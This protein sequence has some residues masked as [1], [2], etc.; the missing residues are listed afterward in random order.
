MN[1][2]LVSLGCDKN[3]VDSEKILY[4][5][6]SNGYSITHDL[7]NVDVIIINTCA[8]IE[9]AKQESV[10]VI[11]EAIQFQSKNTIKIIVVGCLAQR[12]FI[13]LKKEFPT[14]SI[15]CLNEYEKITN[16]I[17]NSNLQHIKSS[18]KTLSY[19]EKSFDIVHTGR[20]LTTPCHIA[21]LKIADGCDNFC[22]YCA[23]PHIRGR[24]RSIPIDIL[25]KE[26][27]E[28][29]KCG[30]K[31]LILVAQD[32]TRYGCD[33]YNKPSLIKLLQEL[34][35]INFWKIRILYAYPEFVEND[36]IE[37]ISDNKN[38]AK[39]I[40]MP[41][42]HINDNLLKSMN[43]K[44]T[45]K[46]ILEKLDDIHEINPDISIRSSFIVGYPGETKQQFLELVDF[47]KTGKIDYAGFFKYSRE[48]NTK[49]YNMK[50]QISKKIKEERFEA[51]YNLQLSNMIEKNNLLIGCNKEIIVDA[52]DYDMGCFVGR[53]EQSC[54]EV[55]NVVYIN[56]TANQLLKCGDIINAKIDSA[57]VDLYATM[58]N[59]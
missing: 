3:R 38:L 50:N 51:L 36:L 13:E 22:S 23:I 4:M 43:R 48:E 40:D 25:L 46:Y 35:N 57:C 18:D 31:E 20:I 58:A 6:E 56:A 52:F 11:L 45:R 42:Q 24:Y 29:K 15:V 54:Y 53:L 16:V 9:D 27:Y 17:E 44:I 34:N 59:M 55:D 28:L 2:G 21:Y 5:L 1:I 39:Y 33:L 49:A 32:V 7:Q 47:I 19:D 26:A 30:V 10:D 14:I 8:F 37:Y 41:I 12:Y